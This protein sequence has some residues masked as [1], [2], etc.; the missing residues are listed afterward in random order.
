MR[1]VVSSLED[2]W[3]V[4]GDV[5]RRTLSG[6][7]RFSRRLRFTYP[8]LSLLMYSEPSRVSCCC[9]CSRCRHH[10]CCCL[11]LFFL[12]LRLRH[13]FRRLYYIAPARF[14]AR[15]RCSARCIKVP[16]SLLVW[17]RTAGSAAALEKYVNPYRTRPRSTKTQCR[18][19]DASAIEASRA[20]GGR[21]SSIPSNPPA[22]RVC[23]TRHPRRA[24]AAKARPATGGERPEPPSAGAK[25]AARTPHARGCDGVL[26]GE[27]SQ[28]GA[29]HISDPEA[30][31]PSWVARATAACARAS[32]LFTHTAAKQGNTACVIGASCTSSARPARPTACDHR[33]T[34]TST[35]KDRKLLLMRTSHGHHLADRSI[36]LHHWKR[37]RSLRS[38]SASSAVV[39]E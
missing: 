10:R 28:A 38:A 19:R 17:T 27:N 11:G 9:C 34:S 31:C 39:G 23:R 13:R 21:S 5:D 15:C 36:W 22:Q 29:P 2:S 25:H 4:W 35:S 24:R 8:A 16:S 26:D 37:T 32:S 3:I 18:A 6:P 20:T 14:V 12:G 1:C 30:P 33:A 7:A